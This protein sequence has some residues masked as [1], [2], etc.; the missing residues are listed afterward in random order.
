M[1]GKHNHKIGQLLS[2]PLHVARDKAYKRL[3]T[4]GG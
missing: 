1:E 3:S 4:K 2:V